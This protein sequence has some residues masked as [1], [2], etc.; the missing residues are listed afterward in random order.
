[1]NARFGADDPHV[2]AAQVALDDFKEDY[3]PYRTLWKLCM[4][5]E[6]IGAILD[7]NELK[8][9]EARLVLNAKQNLDQL[10]DEVRLL[11]QR[12]SYLVAATALLF[13]VFG[14]QTKAAPDTLNQ[15]IGVVSIVLTGA[16]LVAAIVPFAP[17]FWRAWAK[18]YVSGFYLTLQPSDAFKTWA[19]YNYL[20]DRRTPVITRYKRAHAVAVPLLVVATVATVVGL[21]LR[22]LP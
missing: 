3:E 9:M 8:D 7:P 20:A 10:N 12:S 5:G 17:P 18:P 22:T 16:T 15:V 14:L 1:M 19:W 13:V 4:S 11:Q 2:R 21:L 6:V